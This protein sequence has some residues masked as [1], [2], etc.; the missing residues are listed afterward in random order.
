[1]RSIT[2]GDQ[3]LS[4]LPSGWR[5]ALSHARIEPVDIGMSDASVFRVGTSHFL[6]IAQGA[7]ADDLRQEIDRTAWLGRQGI[8]VA[9][10]E[11]IHDEGVVVAVLNEALAGSSADETTLAPE[12]VV[13]ALARA[14]SALHALPVRDCPFDESVAVRLRRAGAMF[15]T[16]R[17]DPAAFAPR[18]RDVS[19]GALIDRLR[20]G[21]PNE[22]TAVVH[23]DATLS[24]LIVGDDHSVAFIDCGHA[25]RAD[26]YVDIALVIEGLSE[27]FGSAAVDGFL[28]VY[29]GPT[30]DET[31]RDYFLD[32]YEL[33]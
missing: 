7:G 18:N 33:F 24:N 15:E 29:G 17:I 10:M 14:L 23:G 11:R 22:E 3:L 2:N 12:I 5:G 31:K 1:M 25:G 13:P 32:L 20:A 27:R 4:M 16:G 6:K 26:P 30:I 21:K 8:R 28:H 9:R 19:P